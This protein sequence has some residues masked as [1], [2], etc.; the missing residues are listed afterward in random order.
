[1][2]KE[3]FK[4][5]QDFRVTNVL[6]PVKTDIKV[7]PSSLAETLIAEIADILVHPPAILR[8]GVFA[9]GRPCFSDGGNKAK[10]AFIEENQGNSKRFRLFLYVATYDVSI[11]LFYSHP[12][13]WLWSQAS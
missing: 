5:N 6:R 2:P 9:S 8:I 12:A 1:M 7:D 11:V 13:L 4:E 10:P 3:I